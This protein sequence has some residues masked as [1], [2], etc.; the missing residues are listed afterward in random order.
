MFGAGLDQVGDGLGL[1]QVELVVE[2]CTLAE[3]TGPSQ[4]CTQLQATAQQQVEHHRAAMALQLQHV[5]ACEG[6]GAGEVD[7]QAFVKR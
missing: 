1:G 3:L 2:K 4:A 7:G 6:V 5:F